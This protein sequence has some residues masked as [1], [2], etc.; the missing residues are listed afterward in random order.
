MHLLKSPAFQDACSEK[1]HLTLYAL[2]WACALL[3][4]THML[5]A[6]RLTGL[7]LSSSLLTTASSQ[8]RAKGKRSAAFNYPKNH[9]VAYL[10]LACQAALVSAGSP[11]SKYTGKPTI[12]KSIWI[13]A[14]VNFWSSHSLWDF[15][16]FKSWKPAWVQ[17][18]W[19]RYNILSGQLLGRR[20]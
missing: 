1:C 10:G 16:S 2:I 13:R 5:H 8:G 12:S 3:R 11:E 15:Y 17:A 7:I 9:L 20:R 19:L 6:W 14:A 4:K 18:A